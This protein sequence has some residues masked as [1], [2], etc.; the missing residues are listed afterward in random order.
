M[1]RID[2]SYICKLILLSACFLVVYPTVSAAPVVLVGELEVVQEDYFDT[3]TTKRIHLLHEAKTGKVYR[4]Q[5]KKT[6]PGRLVSGATVVA[7]G[8]LS[9]NRR[10]VRLEDSTDL[11]FVK[12]SVAS[13]DPTR[14]AVVMIVDFQ[15][16]PVSCSDADITETMFTGTWSVDGLYQETS[17]GTLSF[18]SDTDGD[19]SPDVLR[20]SINASTGD[21]CDPWSWAD[22]AD[23]EAVNAQI[24]L[25]LYEHRV[26]VLPT[27]TTCGWA[28][29]AN[30]GCGT[31]CRSFNKYCFAEDVYAHELG[32]NLG[33]AHSSTDEDNDGVIDCEYCDT[34]DIMGY[35][36][37]GW[38][39]V[40][41]PHKFEMS[42]LPTGQVV[43]LTPTAPATHVIAPLEDDPAQAAFPQ[44]IKIPRPAGNYYYVSY[45]VQVGYD[46]GLST[47]YA[48]KTSIHHSAPDGSGRSR[49]VVALADGEIFQDGTVSITQVS[50]DST[51]ATLL[52]EG[53]DPGCS[54]IDSDGVCG[55]VDNCPGD[56]NPDQSDSDGDGYGDACDACPNDPSDDADA[57]GVCGDVDN[58]PDDANPTQVDTDGDGLGD[59]CDGCPVD[60]AKTTPGVCGCGVADNDSDSDGTPDCNDVCPYDSS[61]DADGDSVCED[62]DNCPGVANRNQRDRDGDGLGDACDSCQDDPTNDVDGDGICGG[63]DNCPDVPNAD[64]IDSDGDGRGDACGSVVGLPTTG[65]GDFENSYGDD[66]C[67]DCAD[68]TVLDE[69][70]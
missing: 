15:D 40:N 52:I 26:Y 9:K 46:E 58:C 18:P 65:R 55:D 35:A 31:Y 37:Q 64:Q 53:S 67:A 38:R 39:Q 68:E 10:I 33:L 47:D 14:E 30:V 23:A 59:A 7:R 36:G 1:M 13:L 57:D 69:G 49:F 54:D 42:W 21:S 50:H 12:S 25:D 60:P 5:F 51:S 32:H 16:A 4:L 2:L 3:D 11:S 6:P 70:N 34:S 66:G 8:V 24:D 27:G 29:L 45:R 61:D 28:G 63:V 44:L 62:V 48:Y 56:P 43:D 41:G 19:G 22:L 20:V 17:F